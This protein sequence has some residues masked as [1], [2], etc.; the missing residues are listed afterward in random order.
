MAAPSAASIRPTRRPSPGVPPVGQAHAR[1]AGGQRAQE[2]HRQGHPEQ[3]PS[4][5]AREPRPDGLDSSATA[6]NPND[7]RIGSSQSRS[8]SEPARAPSPSAAR[9]ATISP[10][11]WEVSSHAPSATPAASDAASRTGGKPRPPPSHAAAA[12]AAVNASGNSARCGEGRVERAPQ[13][14]RSGTGP[15]RTTPPTPPGRPAPPRPPPAPLPVAFMPGSPVRAGR[16]VRR[17]GS[18]RRGC[19]GRRSPDAAGGPGAAR[20]G[21]PRRR[22]R[23]PRDTS[24]RT[25]PASAVGSPGIRASAANTAAS[26]FAAWRARTRSGPRPRD[27]WVFAARLTRHPD[28]IASRAMNEAH[29][30]VSSAIWG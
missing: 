9:I 4:G 24:R 3:G 22:G 18:R 19:G 16:A 10:P 30:M 15:G 27:R 11:G 1:C 25:G 26:W 12:V 23:S 13:Q 21:R 5:L 7:S 29:P 14:S 20:S 17:G 28:S 2:E 8:P 6:P